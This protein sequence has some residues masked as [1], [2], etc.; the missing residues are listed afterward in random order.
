MVRLLPFPRALL[1]LLA[2]VVSLLL[3]PAAISAFEPPALSIGSGNVTGAYYAVSSAIAKIFNRRSAEFGMRLA[4]VKSAGSLANID[5]VLFGATAFGMAQADVL[6]RAVLG[7]GGPWEGMPRHELRALLG[8]HVEA[9][10]IVAG[11]DRTIER[12]A[13]LRGK[14][15]NIGEPG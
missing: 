11:A 3:T 1:P 10:T 2:A 5:A 12:V 4:T 15:V 13:D 6:E 9:V 8:L 7:R 14:R